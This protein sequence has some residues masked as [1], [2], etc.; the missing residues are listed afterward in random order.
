M[1][2]LHSSQISLPAEKRRNASR[3]YNRRTLDELSL[4]AP[5]IPWVNYANRQLQ[6]A[7]H[8]VSRTRVG[9]GA[10]GVRGG[11]IGLGRCGVNIQGPGD[12]GWRD[13]AH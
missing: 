5:A 8:T 10:R 12:V 1:A 2:S 11:G 6:P 13:W 4:V 9:D 7:G 3:L